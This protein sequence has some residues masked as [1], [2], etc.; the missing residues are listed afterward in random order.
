M[1]FYVL[2]KRNVQPSLNS[3]GLYA[4]ERR[5]SMPYILRGSGKSRLSLRGS[6]LRQVGPVP[7]LCSISELFDVIV[8]IFIDMDALVRVFRAEAT[9]S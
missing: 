2:P 8:R 6:S 4:H 1:A 9:G 7:C 3:C 5:V